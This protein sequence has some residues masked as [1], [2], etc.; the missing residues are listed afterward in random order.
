MASQQGE[1]GDSDAPPLDGPRAGESVNSSLHADASVLSAAQHEAPK[2][3]GSTLEGHHL[4]TDDAGVSRNENQPGKKKKKGKHNRR[5]TRYKK[6]KKKWS[7]DESDAE[8]PPSS[9]GGSSLNPQAQTFNPTAQKEQILSTGSILTPDNTSGAASSGHIA[10]PAPFSQ[11]ATMVN[12]NHDPGADQAEPMSSTEPTIN[13]EN[14][15]CDSYGLAGQANITDD[16]HLADDEAPRAVRP[17]PEAPLQPQPTS[18]EDSSSRFTQGAYHSFQRRQSQ[19]SSFSLRAPTI[20]SAITEQ[21][22][23]SSEEERRKS[24]KR[25]GKE[26]QIGYGDCAVSTTEPEESQDT[27]DSITSELF[28]SESPKI[29]LA[30]KKRKQRF[31]RLTAAMLDSTANVSSSSS[32]VK[33]QGVSS[34]M[35]SKIGDDSEGWCLVAGRRKTTRSSIILMS[36]GRPLARRSADETE[37]ARL[38]T[39]IS[40]N[41]GGRTSVPTPRPPAMNETEYPPLPSPQRATTETSSSLGEPGPS[42]EEI[43]VQAAKI[44]VKVAQPVGFWRSRTLLY[45]KPYGR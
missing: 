36:R 41:R 27:C 3:G 42:L 6:P 24:N 44:G 28:Q 2:V 21:S 40:K 8:Q 1:P 33:R 14:A 31:S 32:G 38:S 45:L 22:S 26:R 11:H 15:Q 10:S 39:T 7:D 30:A 4:P 5:I 17:L 16:G 18:K 37:W 20:L 9:I 29:S 12:E 23:E 19:P 13:Y 25:K 34:V 43:A 35:E